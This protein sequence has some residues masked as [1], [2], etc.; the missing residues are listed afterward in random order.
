MKQKDPTIINIPKCDWCLAVA[1]GCLLLSS[2]VIIDPVGNLS[3]PWFE[4][5]IKIV[6]TFF[7]F[8]RIT[9]FAT[10]SLLF[11]SLTARP[12]SSIVSSLLSGLIDVL[13][14]VVLVVKFNDVA[15]GTYLEGASPWCFVALMACGWWFGDSISLF[16]SFLFKIRSKKESESKGL[17]RVPDIALRGM[18]G[19]LLFCVISIPI[20]FAI[21]KWWLPS[22][23][24]M[25]GASAVGIG[26]VL[27]IVQ[28]VLMRLRMKNDGRI[29]LFGDMVD[30]RL[31]MSD[32]MNIFKPQI[33]SPEKFDN[34]RDLQ[35]KQA[36]AIKSSFNYKCEWCFIGEDVVTEDVMLTFSGCEHGVPYNS[37]IPKTAVMPY[38][39]AMGYGDVERIDDIPRGVIE[40]AAY[41]ATLNAIELS[42]GLSLLW[43]CVCDMRVEDLQTII[44][45]DTSINRV[46]AN[47]GGWTALMMAVAQGFSEG[48]RLLLKKGADPDVR[49]ANGVTPVLWAV[50]Y[51]NLECLKLLYDAGANI[52]V[53]DAE[54]CNALVVAAKSGSKDVVQFLVD[55]GV[56]PNQPDLLGF[57]AL[58]YAQE[59]KNG[60]I[61]IMLRR[62][63]TQGGRKARARKRH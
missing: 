1:V 59:R 25:F 34:P 53:K 20:L 17:P 60:E 44:D 49:N 28:D 6:S 23:Y 2:W 13:A 21:F 29:G 50:R 58:Q 3:F 12:K 57:T 14:G 4:F 32:Q 38:L 8:T 31:Q 56:N 35:L 15:V 7:T 47:Q 52:R 46:Y 62:R 33:P 5:P 26:C 36:Q 39:K 41:Y 42:K 10:A 18:G 48:V 51:N 37:S 27:A 61:A 63:I 43:D 30:R 16:V 55:H 54:G 9:W 19:S 11:V 24:V 22:K 45:A 40:K